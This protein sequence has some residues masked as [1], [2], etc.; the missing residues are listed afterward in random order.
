VPT[1]PQ[2]T[3]SVVKPQ[4][5]TVVAEPGQS[6]Q[7]MLTVLQDGLFLPNL[8]ERDQGTRQAVAGQ[9]PTDGVANVRPLEVSQAA[10][11]GLY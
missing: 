10:P 9:W 8:L 2:V 3:M 1:Y 5:H 7:L 6:G 11:E 4:D